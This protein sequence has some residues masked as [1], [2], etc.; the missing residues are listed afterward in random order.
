MTLIDVSHQTRVLTSMKR[1]STILSFFLITATCISVI[2][3]VRRHI[4]TPIRGISRAA[5]IFATGDLKE[6]RITVNSNDE[7]GR[8]AESI[9]EMAR[10][11]DH[12]YSS[13]VERSEEL[14]KLNHSLESLATTDGLTG[15][16]NH[17]Y[18]FKKLTEEI[19]RSRRYNHNLTL[20]MS[21][22]DHFKTY[23]DT[24]GHL[25]G[26]TLLKEIAGIFIEC[27]RD[28]D[29]VARYGGE[30]FAIILPE[31]AELDAYTCAERIRTR[32]ETTP[33]PHTA[34][35]PDGKLTMSFGIARLSDDMS[36][37]AAFVARADSNLYRAKRLGRNRIE[38]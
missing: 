14:E 20:I 30:E 11:L 22:V 1:Y 33:F 7:I 18:L 24:N 9:N 38:L 28:I 26:D 4:L 19:I 37:A 23:N 6:H 17:R 29:I 13:A 32:I 21:D 34:G 15:I 36:D 27:T 5:Q 2:A 31:T 25:N 10:Q 3:L 8:L 12:H 35:Q 16:Y